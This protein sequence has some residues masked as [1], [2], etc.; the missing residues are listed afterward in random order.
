MMLIEKK[1]EKKR[2][3]EWLLP[4]PLLLA[5][6]YSSIRCSGSKGG[7]RVPKSINQH[8]A[9]GL[10]AYAQNSDREEDWNCTRL[11]AATEAG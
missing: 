5:A 7:R 10:L 4:L 9:M 6:Q 11:T 1:G 3:K 8:G 2:E